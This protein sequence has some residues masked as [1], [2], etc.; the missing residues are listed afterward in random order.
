VYN[1]YY[2]YPPGYNYPI[3]SY[4]PAG[5]LTVTSYPSNAIVTIDGYNQETTPWIYTNLLPGY[6]T[7]EINYPGYEAYVTNIYVDNGANPEVDANL[8]SLVSYGS[9][10]VESTPSGSDV[11][12]D[13]N[14]EG[15]SP[16]TVSGLAAGPHIVELHHT[17]Y[18]VQMRTVDVVSGQGANVNIAMTGYTSSTTEGSID[19]TSNVPGAMVYLDGTYKG[20]TQ[21]GNIFNVI[22]VS[23]G[24]HTLLLHAPGY[25]DFTETIQID[26]GQIASANVLFS[27]STQPPQSSPS[28]SQQS[29]SIFAASVPSGGQV[30]LD[31]QF[32]G[33][34]PVTIYNVASGDHIVNMKLAGYSD[35]SG[36]LSVQPG[37]VAQVAATFSPGTGGTP[38]PTRAGLPVAAA[39]SAVA[40]G[41]LIVVSRVRK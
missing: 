41:A 16:V 30:F 14:Y 35:W 24:S 28:S 40:I 27:P 8:L 38:V 23:P 36:S 7:V 25:N 22:A 12:V 39:L 32:R 37:Q 31:N 5:A 9:M 13:G 33:I 34:A 17:G 19:I 21:G 2:Y 26:A 4:Y 1:P 20:Q 3:N 18:D 15:V 29:G 6:H 10:F 11:F